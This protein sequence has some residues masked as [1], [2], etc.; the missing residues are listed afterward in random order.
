MELSP[1][2]EE[3]GHE[4]AA[5]RASVEWRLR[6][7]LRALGLGLAAVVAVSAIA[8]LAAERRNALWGVVDLCV[9][10][11]RHTGLPFPC[12]AV[13]LN[14]GRELGHVVLRPPIGRPDT[15]LSPTRRSLGIEDAWLLTPEAPNYFD[16]AWRNR[17]YVPNGERAS[18]R[19]LAMG[20]SINSRFTRSQDQLH[21]HM[22]CLTTEKQAQLRRIAA[23]APA[24]EWV[25]AP[26]FVHGQSAWAYRAG[27][28]HFADL[29]PFRIAAERFGESRE[30]VGA[31]TLFAAPVATAA[32]DD[33]LLLA[34]PT[35]KPR[36]YLDISSEDLLDAGCSEFSL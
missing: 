1:A 22:G 28:G 26:Q 9:S 34:F 32:G 35:Q 3:P 8:A 30:G 20:L 16:E 2:T 13:D 5:A 29:A 21:I 15:I 33:I 23:A 10:D 31:I 14:R 11:A 27:V 12:L 6:R 19:P 18:Q 7:L 17:S 25:L 4:A 36:F 24:R